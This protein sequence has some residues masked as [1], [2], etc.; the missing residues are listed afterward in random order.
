[1]WNASIDALKMYAPIMQQDME[2]SDVQLLGWS[3]GSVYIY[4]VF[5]EGSETNVTMTRCR[6]QEMHV[7]FGHLFYIFFFR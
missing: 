1:M 3:C 7:L 4:K 5:A 2:L 6:G